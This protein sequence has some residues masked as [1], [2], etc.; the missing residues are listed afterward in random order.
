[1]ENYIYNK[2]KEDTTLANLLANGSKFHIYPGV[3]PR[4]IKF[5]QAITHSLINSTDAYPKISSQNIQFNIFAKKH[6][7]IVE[8][9]NALANLFNEDNLQTEA[10]VQ[11]VFSIRK[12][13]TDLGYDYDEKIY[14]REASY[15]FKLR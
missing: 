7:K 9:A 6:K 2:I 8:V 5:S 10:G 12:S 11:V 3:I 1:M 4:G 14:Q 13:E 15:Y